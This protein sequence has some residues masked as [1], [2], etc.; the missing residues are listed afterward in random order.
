MPRQTVPSY[1]A[2]CISRCG[3]LATVEDGRLI[4]VAADPQ[5]PTGGALC[6]KAKAAPELVAHPERLTT[7]L[8]R[9][10]PK[11]AADPGWRA[12]G[13][14]EALALA[15]ERLH[16]A[17]P[18]GTAFAVATPS[19]TAIADSFGWIHRLA[20]AWGSPNL[21][22]ATENCNWHRD[23]SPALTWGAGLGMPD[24]AA[25]ATILLWGCNPAATWLAHAD[26]IRDAQRR[27]A[28]LI[29][30]DPRQS[31]LGKGADLWLGLRPG[32]DAALALGLIHL[33]LAS[34]GADLEFL[35]RHSDAFDPAPDG[36]GSVLEHLEKHVAAWP[37]QRVAAV[38]G[39]SEDA[40]YRT[41]EL[42]AKAKPVSLYTWTGSCQQEQASAATRAINL[43]YALTGSLGQPGGNRWFPKP[44]L[45]DIAAFDA[46]SA[47]T[48]R[49]TLGLAE[50]PLG[51]P[52]RGWIT[53]R[54]LFHAIVHEQP[55]P[56]RALVAFGGNFLVS[57]PAT[58]HTDEAL[59]KLD[60]F[61]QTEL[62]ETPSAR[63]ADLL[64]PAAS[65]WERE[66][67]QAGFMVDAAA[68]A[69]IQLR[70]ALVE[71]PG[72]ARSDTAIVFGLAHALGLDTQFF[73]GD[74][75][76]GLAHILV[77]SGLD[78]ATLRLNPRGI[79][80]PHIGTEPA[81]PSITLW[82][83]AL[84]AAGAGGFPAWQVPEADPAHPFSLTC[85]KT[86]AYC[87]SQF[88]QI[89]SLRRRQPEPLVEI[90][91]D[92]AA[93]R[94]IQTG[95]AVSVRTADGEVHYRAEINPKLAA[96]TLWAH[97]GWWHA[98]QPINYNA[99]MN[100]EC[101]DAVS[102]SNALRGIAC[103]VQKMS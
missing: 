74:A 63:W 89:D 23:F 59:A 73:D 88:R 15:G 50:R 92:V 5:H 99:A 1:C 47:E 24:Y 94:N 44:R 16:A 46:V 26:R 95:D 6:I 86:V 82:S 60:F 71:P 54:D 67:L 77:P 4:S 62:F 40:L 49:Q 3:C 34:G 18:Q 28:K 19:G 64:L 35:R 75:E 69:H 53:S 57:K 51:P 61:V 56:I 33:L 84:A 45:N 29:V 14:D 72:E 55:Y 79:A 38:T 7:P 83:P 39:L 58:R 85:G 66:G 78:A 13:W 32:T 48:R 98:E 81:P 37:P 90:A 42:L 101:F 93:A 43:L 97:Y 31:G 21:V 12:I 20:H 30:I 41:A 9:T 87:H 103:D 100:G 80:A 17:G 68:E 25:T 36:R 2:L 96:N 52:S 8:L 91:P 70:P 10:K 102:G 76:A 65:C 22:F 27:G 11:G